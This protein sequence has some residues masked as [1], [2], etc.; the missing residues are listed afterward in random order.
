MDNAI[1]HYL[2]AITY[3]LT[4][5]EPVSEQHLLHQPSPSV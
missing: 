5:A 2:W 1:A 3:E 4:D